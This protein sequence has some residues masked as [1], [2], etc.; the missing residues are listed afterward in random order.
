[1]VNSGKGK[2]TLLPIR[3]KE[4]VFQ[5]RWKERK[6]DPFKNAN[7]GSRSRKERLTQ[8]TKYLKDNVWKNKK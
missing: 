5:E 3:E 4:Y 1:M 6:Q 7:Q 8:K 2:K